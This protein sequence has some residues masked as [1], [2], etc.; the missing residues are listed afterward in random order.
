MMKNTLT[1]RLALA[2]I[3]VI[4]LFGI[5]WAGSCFPLESEEAETLSRSLGELMEGNLELRIF[6]NNFLVAI[7]GHIPFIG[8]GVMGYI[9]F[10]TGRYLGWLSAQIGIPPALLI[11]FAIIAVYGIL[12]FMGYGVAA[13]ESI[14][15]THRIVY[16]R[17]ALR[18]E[19]RFLLIMVFLSAVFLLAAALIEGTLIRALKT[20]SPHFPA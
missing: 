5:L 7:I 1:A 8:S 18:K 16:A 14:I 11:L 10:Y 6:L 19:I 15:M 13:T 20:L 17:H 9:I 12:E 3:A 2:F 4:I